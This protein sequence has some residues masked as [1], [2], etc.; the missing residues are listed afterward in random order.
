[1]K[2]F[3]NGCSGGTSAFAPIKPLA[4]I[5]MMGAGKSTVAELIAQRC[6]C[7]W[8]DLD[9]LIEQRLGRAIATVFQEDGETVFRDAEARTL[10]ELE[11]SVRN[12]YV[13]ATGGGTPLH[14]ASFDLLAARFCVAWLHAPNQTLFERAFDPKRPLTAGGQEAFS[15]LASRRS[16]CYRTLAQ[17]AVDVGQISAAQAAD[18]IW[19]WWKE[20][21]YESEP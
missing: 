15:M 2:K 8:Y 16:E 1:M 20:H 12:P 3:G 7:A 21:C 13:L 9:C 11:R 18:Q 5:G 19:H 17:L 14:G 10:A 4:L 6:G